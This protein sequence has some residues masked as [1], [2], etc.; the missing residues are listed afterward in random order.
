MCNSAEKQISGADNTEELTGTIEYLGNIVKPTGNMTEK[1]SKD[2]LKLIGDYLEK[3][4]PIDFQNNVK[5]TYRTEGGVNLVAGDVTLNDFLPPG[6]A[7]LIT[8]RD[9][10][11]YN[12][13][14]TV[15]LPERYLENFGA[16]ERITL[17][18]EVGHALTPDY[19]KNI[20]YIKNRHEFYINEKNTPKERADAICD[21]DS[22]ALQLELAAWENARVIAD[23]FGVD[24]ITF[25][26]DQHRSLNTYIEGSIRALK[27][28]LESLN[29]NDD[30]MVS[31]FDPNQ[32][33]NVKMTYKKFM[34]FAEKSY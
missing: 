11:E 34:E 17:A 2:Y 21:A 18:H 31:I 15:F 24:E 29:L 32:G 9:R 4:G 3:N 28:N 1:E 27:K 16:K 6:L 25:D 26:E 12:G 10:P 22:K 14:Q 5:A 8:D 33:H 19:A 23:L 13:R 30:V 20:D 7:I